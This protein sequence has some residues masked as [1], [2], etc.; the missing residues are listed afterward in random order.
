MP[1]P[2]KRNEA[3]KPVSR[4]H[5]HGL[6]LCWKIRQGLKLKV[7]PV[8]IKK[9]LDWF[10]INYLIPHFEIEEK[11]IF[12]LLGNKHPMVKRALAEHRRLKR[13]FEN[14]NDLSKTISM[15]EEELAKHIRFEERVLFNEVQNIA[16]NEQLLQL[17]EN[18]ID[19]IFH[20]NQS[21][22]FWEKT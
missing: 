4:D 13:L 14:D 11:F 3:L 16:S 6:L 12:P 9:Y 19:K 8:R 21:D 7:E 17:Q 10:W 22:V 15:I 1:S 5:H 18:C 2:I 20:E